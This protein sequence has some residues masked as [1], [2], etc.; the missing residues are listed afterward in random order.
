MKSGTIGSF[1]SQSFCTWFAI[2][3]WPAT[4]S[5]FFQRSSSAVAAES[6]KC[7][8]LPVFTASCPL[9][10]Y[11]FSCMLLKKNPYG[12]PVAA[13]CHSRVTNFVLVAFGNHEPQSGSSFTLA[14]IP[15]SCRFFAMIW[16]DA[17]QSDQPEMTWIWEL[18]GLP[19]G[20]IRSLPLYVKP[21]PVRSAFAAEGLYAAIFFASARSDA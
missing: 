14:S 20:S 10:R 12:D 3:F 16:S 6:R 13:V 18:T 5:V 21:A 19:F 17:T 11:V 2:F 8:K 9:G 1:W 15:I 7:A 4:S